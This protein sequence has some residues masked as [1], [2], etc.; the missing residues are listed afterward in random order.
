MAQEN[1][2]DK[3][4]VLDLLGG[5]PA[6]L[7]TAERLRPWRRSCDSSVDEDLGSLLWKQA[8]QI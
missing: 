6:S 8:G 2:L 7:S 5:E 3:F 1:V 4:E